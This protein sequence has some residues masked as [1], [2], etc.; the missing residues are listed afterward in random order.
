MLRESSTSTATTFCCGRSVA[1]LMA[2]CHN[3]RSTSATMPLSSSQ[4]AAGRTP[5]SMPWFRR[6]CQS[7]SA[8]AAATA[9]TSAHTGHGARKTNCPFSKHR[10]RI[11]EQEFE[12]K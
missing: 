1:T 8:A 3:S 7:S 2:G 6:T 5:V 12:H 9:H 11:L 4:M 10:A